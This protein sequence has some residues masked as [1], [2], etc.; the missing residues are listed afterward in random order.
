[1]VGA[2]I[3]I[4]QLPAAGLLMNTFSTVSIVLAAPPA[5]E[6]LAAVRPTLP[7]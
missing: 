3:W 4:V 7:Q 2:V 5:D 1:M 6:T